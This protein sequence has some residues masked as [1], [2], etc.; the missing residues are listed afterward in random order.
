[1]QL[2]FPAWRQAGN[3]SSLYYFHFLDKQQTT[4]SFHEYTI[5]YLRSNPKDYRQDHRHDLPVSKHLDFCDPAPIA[6]LGI[7]CDGGEVEEEEQGVESRNEFQAV[8]F[9]IKPRPGLNNNNSG[10]NPGNK[11]FAYNPELGWIILC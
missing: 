8:R 1:M 5:R 11:N 4:N 7:V 9:Q 10:C 6:N 2:R 3:S